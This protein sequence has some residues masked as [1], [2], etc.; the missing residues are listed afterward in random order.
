MKEQLGDL[1]EDPNAAAE[2]PG[3]EPVEVPAPPA[4]E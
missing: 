3:D 1:P 2:E 4:D